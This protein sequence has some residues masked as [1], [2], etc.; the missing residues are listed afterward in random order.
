M[1]PIEKMSNAARFEYICDFIPL[2]QHIINIALD[3]YIQNVNKDP[4]GFKD[5]FKNTFFNEEA[6]LRDVGA[7]EDVLHPKPPKPEEP[8]PKTKHVPHK[9]PKSPNYS[10][11]DGVLK[12]VAYDGKLE[13]GEKLTDHK[14]FHYIL[15]GSY[16][17]ANREKLIQRMLTHKSATYTKAINQIKDGKYGT[18]IQARFP[19]SAKR[20]ATRT[21]KKAL[22]YD[23]IMDKMFND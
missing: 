11:K 20:K 19:A 8:A 5:M 21:P 6:L 9:S 15:Y 7:V 3:S 17:D 12:G 13:V 14:I 10:E 16:G 23:E 22:T 2:G 18:E 1:K 4:E